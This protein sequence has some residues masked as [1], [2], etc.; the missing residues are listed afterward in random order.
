MNTT[1]GE[2]EPLTLEYCSYLG[3]TNKNGA[4][5]RKGLDGEIQYYDSKFHLSKNNATVKTLHTRKDLNDIIIPIANAEIAERNKK[6][7][8]NPG[9]IKL[10]EESIKD[11]PDLVKEVGL[12]WYTNLSRAQRLVLLDKYETGTPLTNGCVLKMYVAEN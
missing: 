12:D 10:S 4:L 6:F 5:V 9:K 3:L 1:I 8:E 7:R 11:L 2:N